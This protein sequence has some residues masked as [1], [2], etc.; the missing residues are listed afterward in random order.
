MEYCSSLSDRWWS[1][2]SADKVL[3]E[4]VAWFVITLV[5]LNS[6]YPLDIII[7]PLDII[8]VPLEDLGFG[9]LSYA[10]L[11]LWTYSPS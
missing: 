8:I 9:Q 3:V 1:G 4:E 10:L 7:V 2:T 5:N 11:L 6:V